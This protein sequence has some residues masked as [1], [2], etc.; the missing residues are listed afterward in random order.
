MKH[1]E[2]VTNNIFLQLKKI[3]NYNFR[4]DGQNFFD[5]PI[6]ND[7]KTLIIF[8]KFERVKVMVTQLVVCWTIF[9]SKTIIR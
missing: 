8:E 3:K 7:L 5:Q 9:I 1:K 2:E 4:I 6:R